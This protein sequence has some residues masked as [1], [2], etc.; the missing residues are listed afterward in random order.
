M[1]TEWKVIKCK[2][3]K[4]MLWSKYR[5]IFDKKDLSVINNFHIDIFGTIKLPYLDGFTLKC[6]NILIILFIK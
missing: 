6:Y 3:E 2:I 5:H 4:S 1:K